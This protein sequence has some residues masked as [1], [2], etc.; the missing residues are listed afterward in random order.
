M[1][2]EVVRRHRE[3]I[4]SRRPEIALADHIVALADGA[5]CPM[6]GRI[7]FSRTKEIAFR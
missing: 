7:S 6:S 4:K 3:P 1:A 5:L 2:L